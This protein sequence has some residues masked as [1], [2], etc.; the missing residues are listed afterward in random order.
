LVTAVVAAVAVSAGSGASADVVATDVAA[1]ATV[2]LHLRV[3]LMVISYLYWKIIKEKNFKK[4]NASLYETF[5]NRIRRVS[6]KIS[7]KRRRPLQR[8]FG[9]IL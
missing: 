7:K 8:T 3:L 6:H 9:N 1:A 5:I 4:S 2:C